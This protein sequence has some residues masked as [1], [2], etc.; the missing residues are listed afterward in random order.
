MGEKN[1]HHSLAVT[2]E[3]EKKKTLS[4]E[5]EFPTPR[6]TFSRKA[7]VAVERHQESFIALSLPFD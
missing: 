4:A 5:Q 3:G 1:M 6:K 7:L 2:S